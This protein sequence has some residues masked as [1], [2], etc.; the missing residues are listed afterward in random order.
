M[1]AIHAFRRLMTKITEKLLYSSPSE[2][3]LAK[4]T[5]AESCHSVSRQTKGKTPVSNQNH[6][7]L[8]RPSC[9]HP[10]AKTHACMG[11]TARAWLVTDALH[12]LLRVVAPPTNRDMIYTWSLGLEE[13]RPDRYM[14]AVDSTEFD[15]AKSAFVPDR[16]MAV[17]PFAHTHL[18]GQTTSPR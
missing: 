18:G 16:Y 13:S 6:Q 9:G 10:L 12:H 8:L 4:K 2:R 14:A 17:P 1:R 5:E 11:D 3:P 15:A 7:P